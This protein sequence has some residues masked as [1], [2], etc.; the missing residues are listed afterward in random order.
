MINSRIKKDLRNYL[1]NL[2]EKEKNLIKIVSVYPL[3]KQE[4]SD[5]ANFFSISSAE[6]ENIIDPSIIGGIVIN[7]GSKIIDLS[8]KNRLQNIKK[9]Y[10]NY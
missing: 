10:D 7:Q 5:L 2:I 9:K 1:K 6:I 3:S 4:I 8:I